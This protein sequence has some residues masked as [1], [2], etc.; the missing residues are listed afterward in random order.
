[1]DTK[2]K[3]QKKGAGAGAD[4]AANLDD[5]IETHDWSG[6]QYEQDPELIVGFPKAEEK[7][8]SMNC[9]KGVND[10]YLAKNKGRKLKNKRKGGMKSVMNGDDDF[11]QEESG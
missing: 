3:T 1:M 9:L 2:K 4:S 8:E 7:F 10:D 6:F 5:P 11:D